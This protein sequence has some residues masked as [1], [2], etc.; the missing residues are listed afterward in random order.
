[1]SLEIFPTLYVVVSFPYC[2]IICKN[3]KR[4]KNSKDT[5]L[6]QNKLQLLQ[7]QW[8]VFEGIEYKRSLISATSNYMSS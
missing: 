3:K 8:E 6:F 5:K 7:N 1:M 4:E 2:K